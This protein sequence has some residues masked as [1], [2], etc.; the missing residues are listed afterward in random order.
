VGG[1]C[2]GVDPYYLTYRAEKAGYHPQV[3]LAGRRINDDAGERIARECVRLLMRNGRAAHCVTV[4]GLTFKENVPDI[5]NSKVVDIVR[6]LRS[7]GIDV[8]VHDPMAT[9]ADAEHEYAIALTP[10]Q[11]LKPADAVIL[12][13]THQSY[14]AAGWPLIT[15]LLR[16][17]RGV[18]VDVKGTLDRAGAPEGVILWRM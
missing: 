18:V 12:A 8:Q 11:S 16:D 3:I 6:E 10:E 2:I 7:H 13:V 4:L 1:H 14:V 15:R 9:S 5:R 17:G